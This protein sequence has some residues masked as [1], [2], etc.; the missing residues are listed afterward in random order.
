MIT[1]EA[2]GIARAFLR[3]QAVKDSAAAGGA[4]V[5]HVMV[6]LGEART[7]LATR[8]VN[9]A[10]AVIYLSKRGVALNT[11]F[12]ITQAVGHQLAHIRSGDDT[13]GDAWRSAALRYGV[14]P[15]ARVIARVP[16]PKFELRCLLCGKGV[17]RA[18]LRGPVDAYHVRCG[19][20]SV[21]KLR[22]E[23]L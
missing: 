19:V 20:G 11:S 6:S 9:E 8:A 13:H 18:N 1:S 10:G 17:R 3:E 14:I 21:G 23:R 15:T 16:R 4:Y 22:W 12:E 2:L 5:D 7:A